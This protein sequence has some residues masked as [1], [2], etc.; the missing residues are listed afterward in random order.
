MI[1]P[2]ITAP[3]AISEPICFLHNFSNYDSLSIFS[4]DLKCFLT[5]INAHLF[6]SLQCDMILCSFLHPHMFS[7]IYINHNYIQSHVEDFNSNENHHQ[8]KQLLIIIFFSFSVAC[9]LNS[10]L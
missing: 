6:N 5:Y 8:P 3:P 2:C 4:H 9:F 7:F 1:V 10:Q